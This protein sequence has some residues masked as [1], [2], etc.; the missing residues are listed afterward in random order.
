MLLV[1]GKY[2]IVSGEHPFATQVVLLDEANFNDLFKPSNVPQV[3]LFFEGRGYAERIMHANPRVIFKGACVFVTSNGLPALAKPAAPDDPN[4]DWAAIRTRTT[5]VKM[6]VS[7]SGKEK[8][9]FDATVLAHAILETASQQEPSTQ[10][11]QL[12][13]EKHSSSERTLPAVPEF[14]DD[15]LA[16]LLCDEVDHNTQKRQTPK[17]PIVNLVGKKRTI[18]QI[19]G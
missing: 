17:S 1:E 12:E 5:F 8:F 9:P 15:T 3:K 10:C 18:K 16:E 4:Y 6:T 14:L 19:V 11:S 2:T 13:E 7:H